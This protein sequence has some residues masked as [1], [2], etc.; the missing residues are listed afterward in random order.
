MNIQDAL[1][2]TAVINQKAVGHFVDIYAKKDNWH[3]IDKASGNLGYGWI[4]YSLIRILRP[5]R[6]LCI[7]SRYGYI[8][9][10]CALACRDNKKGHVDFVD[11]N[12]NQYKPE[13]KNHWG[14][15][16]YWTTPEGKQ[17]FERFRLNKHISVHIMTSGKYK[18]SVP[19]KTWGYIHIDG[20]H[21]Y[22]GFKKDLLGLAGKVKESGLL[23]GDDLDLSAPEIN[24]AYAKAHKEADYLEDPLTKKWY[25]PGI[26]LA[27]HEVLGDVTMQNSLWAVVRKNGK[28]HK[29]G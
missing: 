20:D 22:Q 19:Q 3:Q 24:L 17:S 7:G 10:I 15:V 11:A 5:D 14:G 27:V 29:L 26:T 28:W 9:A 8:P 25:H 13:Q 4:H 2:S 18:T 23:S 6:V 16:G 12:Y 1:S 21:S